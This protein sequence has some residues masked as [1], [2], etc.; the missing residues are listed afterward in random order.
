M[1]LWGVGNDYADTAIAT[2]NWAM[3]QISNYPVSAMKQT[4]NER[5]RDVRRHRIRLLYLNQSG[6]VSSAA[7]PSSRI[8]VEVCFG[9]LRAQ[10]RC[11]AVDF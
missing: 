7:V 9:S 10:Y 11:P 8:I 4:T 6:S 5:S 3:M 1:Q 2:N